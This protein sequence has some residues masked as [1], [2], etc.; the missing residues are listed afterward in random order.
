MNTIFLTTDQPIT[1][2]SQLNTIPTNVTYNTETTNYLIYQD[3][4]NYY[5]IQRSGPL[6]VYK[7]PI[8][9]HDTSTIKS[10]QQVINAEI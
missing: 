9:P 5:F 4:T 6:L 8:T 10:V 3:A 2:V 1:N 7:K